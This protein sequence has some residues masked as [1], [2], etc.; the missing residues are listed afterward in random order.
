MIKKLSVI[1]L[2]SSIIF[3]F[4]ILCIFC[5]AAFAGQNEAIAENNNSYQT[6][7]K[8]TNPVVYPVKFFQ[9]HL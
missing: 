5:G 1:R 6:V 4:I 7:E 8:Q 9:N 2:P 3:F